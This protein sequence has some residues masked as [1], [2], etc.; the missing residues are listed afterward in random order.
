MWRWRAPADKAH[1]EDESLRTFRQRQT[2]DYAAVVE[3]LTGSSMALHVT[4]TRRAHAI[5]IVAYF[6]LILLADW[7]ASMRLATKILLIN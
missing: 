2:N 6:I 1:I 3:K 4:F 7:D 5:F